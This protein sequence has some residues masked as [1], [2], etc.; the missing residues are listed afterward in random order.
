MAD[1]DLPV[2]PPLN[3]PALLRSWLL[4]LRAERKARET[5]KSYRTG[6]ERF[7]AWTQDE[8]VPTLLDRPTVNAWT[9][10]MIRNGLEG[11]TVRTRQLAVRLFSTWLADEGEIDIDVLA[12]LKPI[13]VDDKIVEPLSDD[14]LTAMIKTCQG[15]SFRDRRDEAI[16]R[17]MAETTARASETANMTVEDTD[18]YHGTAII[19]RGKG[20]KGRVV[21]FSPTAGRALDRYLRLRRSHKLAALPNLWLGERGRP[22]G[23][24][25]LYQTLCARAEMAGIKGFHPHRLRHTG[26][27]R[28]LTAGGSEGG[29]LAVGGWKDRRM[30]DRYVKATAAIRAAEESR[31]LDLG[32]W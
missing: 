19:R 8:G 21:P 20:G 3:L 14:E 30:L 9:A 11:S 4:A 24:F 10:D 13:K 1:A 32:D 27:T 25:G 26:A 15:K 2:D 31:T 28:W 12:S 29:L 22:L 5:L 7:I 23:Y 18:A 17:I 16:I 6:V